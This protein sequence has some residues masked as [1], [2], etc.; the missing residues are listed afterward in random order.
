MKKCLSIIKVSK[1]G[2]ILIKSKMEN[3]QFYKKY[4]NMMKNRKFIE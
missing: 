1:C 2:V 4:D 3:L